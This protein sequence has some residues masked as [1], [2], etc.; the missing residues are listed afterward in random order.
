MEKEIICPKC[1]VVKFDELDK[2]NI[3]EFGKCMAC[4]KCEREIQDDLEVV[5][6][7]SH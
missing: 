3:E 2:E 5:E 4:E 7:Y 6:E 1:G